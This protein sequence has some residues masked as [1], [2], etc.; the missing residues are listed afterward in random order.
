MLDNNVKIASNEVIIQKSLQIDRE[1]Q[2]ESLENCQ[3]FC[4]FSACSDFKC[5][6]RSLITHLTL[7]IMKFHMLTRV[8]QRHRSQQKPKQEQLL[9]AFEQTKWN[10]QLKA[11]KI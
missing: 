3:N 1:I 6:I 11:V 4:G 10:L 7:S 5:C 8:Q 2:Q 9:S